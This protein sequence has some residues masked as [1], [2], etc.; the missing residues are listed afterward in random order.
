MEVIIS[1]QTFTLFICFCVCIFAYAICFLVQLCFN[2]CAPISASFE[3]R[4]LIVSWFRS[5]SWEVLVLGEAFGVLSVG[6]A[7]VYVWASIGVWRLRGCRVQLCTFESIKV[8]WFEVVKRNW[9]HL[10]VLRSFESNKT[11]FEVVECKLRTSMGIRVIWAEDD[12][13]WGCEVQ[14]CTFE[15]IEVIWVVENLH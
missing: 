3:F 12:H 14:L 1:L 9:A 8:T 7:L 6:R 10:R 4:D 11:W 15:G 5:G 13:I 2:R